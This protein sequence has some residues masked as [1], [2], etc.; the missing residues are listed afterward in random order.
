[1]MRPL[2]LQVAQAVVL[3]PGAPT[4]VTATGGNAQAVVS[5]TAPAS[6]GG[7]PIT[8]YTVTSSPG[9]N[10]ATGTA[11]PITVTGLTNGTAYTFTVRATNK[12]RVGT[13]P[14]SSPSNSVT[15]ATVPGAPTIGTAAA[16]NAQA[17][18]SFAP[19]SNGGSPITSYT[20]TSSPGGNTATGTASP[21][22]VTGLTNST[23]YTFTVTATNALGTGPASAPSNS[24][25]PGLPGAPTIGTAT[26]GIAQAVVSFTAP[27]SNGGSSITSYTVTS[28]PGGITATGT[29][30]PITVTGLTNGTA[31]TFTVTAT[32]AV[33]TGPAS[34][35]SNS[36]TLPTVPGAPTIGTAAA[37]NA[38]AMVSFTA[39][40]SNGG[41]PITSYTVTSSPGGITATGTAS[42]IIVTGLTNGTPYTFTVTATN[43]VGTGPASAP[44]NS[45][46]P[47]IKPT[48]APAAPTNL[49]FV[50][51]T[52]NSITLSWTDNSINEQNF[53]L[54]RSPNGTTGW[55][56]IASVAANTTTYTNTGRKPNTTY[57]YRVRAH[58]SVGNS[59]WT[60]VVSGTTLP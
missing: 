23:A 32:N 5:F 45:V 47:S 49:T 7:S 8:S 59:A 52:S 4:G 48:T 12:V 55:A 10:T 50:S 29:A 26:A 9:G 18:V 53:Q 58:N 21:I 42:P 60:S 2:V 3:L 1:M 28:S 15:P 44:S 54:Q 16:G 35:P 31:Y 41:S 25:T 37:G 40:V 22:T 30:S 56:T 38:Q 27:I 6:N 14:A 39:P 34:S 19:G 33:G 57:F 51:S 43:A 13:G 11:S 36:V 24:V 17:V 20:V 46:V